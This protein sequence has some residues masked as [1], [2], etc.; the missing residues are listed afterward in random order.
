MSTQTIYG[1]L[2]INKPIIYID[3]DK[4]RDVEKCHKQA[5]RSAGLMPL[6]I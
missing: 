3:S 6:T 5:I 2:H 4:A 1:F